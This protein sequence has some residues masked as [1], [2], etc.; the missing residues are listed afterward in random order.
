MNNEDDALGNV[1]I[2]GERGLL[3][4]ASEFFLLASFFL[5]IHFSQ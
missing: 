4:E 2:I 3:S 5:F 1:G